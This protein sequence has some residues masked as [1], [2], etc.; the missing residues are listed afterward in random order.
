MDEVCI[1]NV[2]RQ[3]CAVSS[4]V[5]K[6]KAD[7]LKDRVLDI[8]PH[9]KVSVILGMLIFEIFIIIACLNLHIC[10]CAYIHTYIYVRSFIHTCIHTDAFILT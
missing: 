4:S 5:G 8:N 7:V 1:S 9:A 2:N 3:L 10:A 6:F